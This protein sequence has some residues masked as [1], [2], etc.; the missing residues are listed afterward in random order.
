MSVSMRQRS[1]LHGEKNRADDPK[2]TSAF[3]CVSD[4]T[5][6]QA[7]LQH[8]Q[9]HH[10]QKQQQRQ[11]Q[12]LEMQQQQGGASTGGG[13]DGVQVNNG[14]S[15]DETFFEIPVPGAS[16]RETP[17][18]PSTPKSARNRPQQPKG[19][20][21]FQIMVMY[22]PRSKTKGPDYN[23]P[24]ISYLAPE[25]PGRL[26]GQMLR[27]DY[28][29]SFH[30]TDMRNR[31]M[32]EAMKCIQNAPRDVMLELM[33]GRTGFKRMLSLTHEPR[34]R[35][36]IFRDRLEALLRFPP[37]L[38]ADL[39]RQQRDLL[40]TFRDSDVRPNIVVVGT[41]GTGKSSLVNTAFAALN[42]SEGALTA[43]GDSV[44]TVEYLRF[45]NMVA[46]SSGSPF[47]V[48]DT[49]AIPMDEGRDDVIGALRNVIKGKHKNGARMD[50]GWLNIRAMVD[51]KKRAHGLVLCLD[52]RFPANPQV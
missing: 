48:A 12:M 13:G 31:P 45:E 10:L 30:G 46:K 35:D 32:Q 5:G 25:G 15:D 4:L 37:N 26:S 24:R 43:V 28:L 29:I 42:D 6:V 44:H 41:A 8:M 36:V 19:D 14:V 18:E 34:P 22:D 17:R 33:D 27:G 16:P 2:N 47:T 50:N 1:F 20:L 7:W 9:Q 40:R 38:D 49:C 3:P 51:P 39:L 52:A 21:G 11:Q 23:S